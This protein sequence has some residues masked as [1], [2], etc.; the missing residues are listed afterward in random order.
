MIDD[1]ADRLDVPTWAIVEAAMK[2]A[3][4][5][6]NGVP[7]GWDLPE[8]PTTPTLDLPEEASPRAA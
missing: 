1:Y 8:V 2:A 6:P 7:E 4:P 3:K 5:G